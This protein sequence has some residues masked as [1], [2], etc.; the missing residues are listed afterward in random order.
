MG[1]IV[2]IAAGACLVAPV[3]A[4]SDGFFINEELPIC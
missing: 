2:A 3:S 4:E 1:G